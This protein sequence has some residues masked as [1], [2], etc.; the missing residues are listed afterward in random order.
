M[1]AFAHIQKTAGSTLTWIL[2]RTYGV[3]HMDVEPWRPF[4]GPRYYETTY[5]A[6]DHVQ[7]QRGLPRLE[8][9]A[10]HHVKPHSDLDRVRPDVRYVTFLREPLARTASHYQHMVQKMGYTR[11]CDD[12]LSAERFQDLQTRHIAGR[13]D[14]DEALRVLRERCILVG[15][16]ERFDESLVLLRDRVADPR[17]DVRYR[18]ENVAR[19]PALSRS[20]LEDPAS[21]AVLED[22]NR[23]DVELYARVR[24]EI[25][26]GQ[27]REAGPGFAGAVEAFRADRDAPTRTLRAY[28][29]PLVRSLWVDPRARRRRERLA[30]LETATGSA[31]DP[32]GNR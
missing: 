29:S 20:L 5:S 26:A 8:S 15:L 10:G 30:R 31:R 23:L 32:G 7:V 1:L 28:L 6:E 12:W 19:D 11:S 4:A 13:P 24:D 2:R 3:R 27:V 21:R 17:L 25:F 16:Q 18:S 22:A 14:V 9:V